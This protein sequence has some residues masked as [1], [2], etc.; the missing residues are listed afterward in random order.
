VAA[1]KVNSFPTRR[2]WH[3]FEALPKDIQDLAVKNYELWIQDP[4]HPSLHFRRLQGSRDRVTVRIGDQ[5]RALGKM[6]SADTII[7]VWIGTHAEYDRLV[8]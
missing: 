7:W 5:Y 1:A 8:N 3:L 4:H 6:T 2:F